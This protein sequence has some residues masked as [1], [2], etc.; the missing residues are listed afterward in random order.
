MSNSVDSA[1]WRRAAVPG[2]P[3]L[4]NPSRSASARLA[5]PGPRSSASSVDPCAPVSSSVAC[6]SSS[7]PP[8]CLTRFVAASV[9]TMR[10]PADLVGSTKPR[11]C[12]E[13]A[14]PLADARPR[15]A[16]ASRI[17]RQRVA[18]SL[19]SRD[20][21][22]RPGAGARIDVELVDE[23]RAPPSPR[24]SP[25]PRREAVAQRLLDV[26]DAGTLILEDQ[27]QARGGRR[28]SAP[29]GRTV[30]PPPCSTALRAS[31][32]AAVT[33]FVWSTRLKPHE[34]AHSRTI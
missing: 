29:R 28:R 24:P 25:L 23:A 10:E 11:P 20:R 5:I 13:L 6:S 7:P 14:R 26:R 9:T 15:P 19:P 34:I 18:R 17:S 31:S 27:T 32:L 1:G 16:L 33:I 30:P 8:P 21:H 2:V 22:P 12:G 4:E 3:A